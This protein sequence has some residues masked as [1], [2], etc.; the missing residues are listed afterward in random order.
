MRDSCQRVAAVARLSVLELYRRKD[1]FAALLLAAVILVPL[2][3]FNLFGVEGMSR[4][5]CEVSLLLIWI[6]SIAVGLAVAGRQF[7]VEFESRTIYPLLSKPVR[8]GELLLGKYLGALTASASALLVFYLCHLLLMLAKGG[9]WNGLVLAQGV[10]LHL[11]FMMIL[12]AVGLAGSLWLTPSAN[13]T[14]GALTAAGMLL[15]GEKLAAFAQT[16]PM[17]GAALAALVHLL[18]PHFEFFDIRL[19]IV[20]SW[21]PVAAGVVLLVTAYAVAYTAFVLGIAS[22]LLGRKKL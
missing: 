2:S 1:L 7:P 12:T 19:Q 17:P 5:L 13:L 20:H 9:P 21:E 11:E 14:V 15:F 6:F 16:G 10:L 3:A 8:R 18:V 22:W 4:Y